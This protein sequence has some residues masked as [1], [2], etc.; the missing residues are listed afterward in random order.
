MASAIAAVPIAVFGQ[1]PA[2]GFQQR[3]SFQPFGVD[4]GLEN[5][6]IRALVQDRS[7]FLW[8]GTRNG[9]YRFDGHRFLNFDQRRGLP[10]ADIAAI[11]ESGDG[12]LWVA[13]SKGLARRV[14]EHFELASDAAAASEINGLAFDGHGNLYGSTRLGLAVAR[15]TAS[16]A[17]DLKIVANNPA[18]AVAAAPNGEGVWFSCGQSICSYI[19]GKVE[20]HGGLPGAEYR[21]LR[22]DRKGKLWTRS[23]DAL[24]VLDGT[25]KRASADA[26]G[27]TAPFLYEDRQG[28]MWTNSSNG[29]ARDGVKLGTAQGLA[30]EG[31]SAVLEDREGSLWFGYDGAGLD[32]R[33]GGAGVVSF[34]KAEGLSDNNAQAVAEDG[35]GG[36][37]VGHATGRLDHGV[38]GAAGAWSWRSFELPARDVTAISRL[39]SGR[40]VISTRRGP[41]FLFDPAS[42]NAQILSAP[43][44]RPLS[45]FEDAAG[46]VMLAYPD[47]V[48][49]AGRHPLTYPDGIVALDAM[50]DRSGRL[51]IAHAGGLA[52]LDSGVWQRFTDADNLVP[53][54]VEHVV[55]GKGGE[56]WLGYREGAG[57]ARLRA[58][59]VKGKGPLDLQHFRKGRGLSSDLVRF[60]KTDSLGRLWVGSDRGADVYDGS[61]WGR[62]GQPQGLIWDEVND[63]AAVPGG[64]GA[65]WIGTRM[66][67]SL[68]RPSA[69]LEVLAKNVIS[70]VD[71][72]SG[73]VDPALPIE[74]NGMSNSITI[75][76]SALQ[77]TDAAAIKYRYRMP[78]FSD[79]WIETGGHQMTL[80][81]LRP[82]RYRFEVQ[83]KREPGGMYEAAPAAL[84]FT[85]A[86]AWMMSMWVRVVGL[87]S[88]MGVFGWLLYRRRMSRV[89]SERRALEA[90]VAD[91]TQELEMQ[92][93]RVEQEKAKA[94][95]QNREI[96]R[97]LDEAKQASR[98]KGEFLA[99]MSHEIRTPM[100][101]IIGMINLALAT[102]LGGDQRDYVETA[103][104][105]AEA[106][107]SILNDVLDFSKVEA[108]H[109]TIDP[110]PFVVRDL[111]SET[112]K[113][114]QHR[115]L[116]KEIGLS[117]DVDAD[118]PRSVVSDPG[119][120]RQV[121]LNLIG[122]AIK[123]THQGEVRVLVSMEGEELHF[124]VEDTGIGIS[125]DKQKV[126][127]EAFRQADGSTTRRYGGTGLGLAISMKLV[128]LMGGRLWLESE[129]G[130][131]SRFH[132]TIMAGL[133]T[134]ENQGAVESSQDLLRMNKVLE[135]SDSSRGR[136]LRILL[137]EDNLVNQRVASR[138]LEVRG[139]VVKVVEN[140][141]EAL[142]ALD[143]GEVFDLILMDVQMPEMDGIEATRLIRVREEIRGGHIPI[144]A[145]TAHTMK[146]DR[147]RCLAAGMDGYVNKPIA[148][149]TFF[150]T[151]EGAVSEVHR[152]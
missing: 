32:R 98:L 76:F 89:E 120:V 34:T 97:L 71:S 113:V 111:V 31:V 35:A 77:F 60:L 131:G 142:Q 137:A 61:K 135:R 112:C 130:K 36:V 70:S 56:I 54:G 93:A 147:E 94:E 17:V 104:N 14:G 23:E 63:A 33:L 62:F 55:E 64:D 150:K 37:W 115:A 74:L 140:G 13:T 109:L 40:L 124:T 28:G 29:A 106:L 3:Y 69:A 20:A 52:V 91:R 117:Y 108:G 152:G 26:G 122:N 146:G 129:Q 149:E 19:K 57:V 144:V 114:F 18:W 24:Y 65:M 51:W 43:S 84:E 99:N 38:P 7:G 12:T 132:F 42:G 148:P 39:R 46:R 95:R 101:G 92:K 25:L 44:G 41:V 128:S 110:E 118:V 145:M 126:V 83:S 30:S 59:S 105:S 85:V 53:G 58:D 78:G 151:V 125:S 123:F 141:A 49:E 10:S 75:R 22:F 1:Q 15:V 72:N 2:P 107:L 8:A 96:E 67:L 90:A 127:F 47:G 6:Q 16:G 21:A 68:C 66:G 136:T 88:A 121:L 48:Y 86:E 50:K 9:L 81:Y 27:P 87:L 82:G 4:S 80:S 103:K 5:L 102:P 100:N 45:V 139:H 116:N 138:M 73:W 133:M 134:A 11:A 119:R 143:C 79:E